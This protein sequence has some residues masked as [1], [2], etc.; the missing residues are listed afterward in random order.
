M[1][2]GPKAAM[3]LGLCFA[4]ADATIGS[5]SPRLV[6]LPAERFSG[7]SGLQIISAK[8]FPKLS[9]HPPLLLFRGQD[10][11]SSIGS[12]DKGLVSLIEWILALGPHLVNL[13][14]HRSYQFLTL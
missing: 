10:Q 4:E 2:F 7:P 9:I 13:G 12:G 14:I 3:H 6:L 5:P 1:A 8:V 11:G